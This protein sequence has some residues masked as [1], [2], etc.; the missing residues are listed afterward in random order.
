MEEA[1]SVALE[2]A[3]DVDEECLTAVLRVKNCDCRRTARD[4]VAGMT[5]ATRE[6]KDGRKEEKTKKKSLVEDNRVQWVW[7]K[8]VAQ[9]L[10]SHKLRFEFGRFREKASVHVI[11]FRHSPFRSQF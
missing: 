9:Q 2:A 5:E 7:V 3:W 1:V 6:R 10:R 4:A 8:S 11:Y